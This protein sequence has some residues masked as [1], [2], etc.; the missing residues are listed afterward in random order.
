[1]KSNTKALAQEIADDMLS[2][3]RGVNIKRKIRSEILN[4]AKKIARKIV[5]KQKKNLKRGNSEHMANSDDHSPKV[6]KRVNRV[7]EK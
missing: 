4:V 7:N 1:M 2:A 6:A 3:N 5:R